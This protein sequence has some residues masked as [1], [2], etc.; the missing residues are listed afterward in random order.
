MVSSEENLNVN[1][2]A[3]T[4]ANN[5][6]VTVTGD[7]SFNT[8][9]QNDGNINAT[10]LNFQVGGDFSY[11][12]ANNDF[13]L[14]ASDNLVVL[15]S[16]FV[17]ADNY[18][19]S[20]VIDIAG[21]L[22]IQVT[23]EARL[24][25]TASIKAKNLFFSV[26][27]FYNQAD[28]TITGNATF[29]IGNNFWNGFY[30]N[31]TYDGGNIN[32]DS[33]NVTAEGSFYNHYFA[34]INADSFNV[35]AGDSFY[36]G[37]GFYTYSATISASD[38]NVTA[39]YSFYN[40]DGATINADDFNVTVTSTSTYSGFY[41]KDGATIDA[42]NFNVTAGHGFANSYDSTIN[43]DNFNV[44][45][46]GFSNYGSAINADNFHVTAGDEF[47]NR[48]NATIS[49]DNFNVTAGDEFYNRDNATISA[50]NFNVTTTKDFHN[51]DNATIN[52]DNFNAT[53]DSFSNYA[54]ISADNLNIS[55]N[56]LD[57]EGIIVG[58]DARYF[59]NVFIENIN[60]LFIIPDGTSSTDAIQSSSGVD[61]IN[62]ARPDSNGL[63]NNS[64]SDFNISSSGLVFNNSASAVSSSLAGTIAG[65]P[66]YSASDSASLI[67]NQITS[68]NASYLGGI[69]E[70]AGDSA[71]IIIANHNG[72]V[73]DAC[74]FANTDKVDLITGTA[75]LDAA[76]M[77]SDYNPF[78]IKR[79]VT[80]I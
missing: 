32:A 16:A 22:S 70:V 6:N 5:L 4:T 24:D 18:T 36:N 11:D 27:D 76:G 65:N 74:S 56:S 59:G 79:I 44:T 13:V 9:F 67:L 75:N 72:I 68:N 37:G 60:N 23:N 71:A 3:N 15:G 50:Y 51:R 38:F 7:L 10:I 26:Y 1:Y 40:R 42:N 63:S 21:D 69:L 25:D 35:L 31:G 61:I 62:I 66:N 49:A 20:G 46:G 29:D 80:N 58:G 57:N 12:D 41:N 55:Y 48:D 53:A 8:E 77:I 2:T 39:G 73:C 19:Q 43:A 14:N 78:I 54:T 45:A 47:H 64:Y 52:A 28:F 33:F 17:T 34:T 30:L